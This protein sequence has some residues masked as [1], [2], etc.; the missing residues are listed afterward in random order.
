MFDDFASD[1]Y[2]DPGIEMLSSYATGEEEPE[3]F[4]PEEIAWFRPVHQ[5]MPVRA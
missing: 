4:E 1:C 2:T 3:S 5:P